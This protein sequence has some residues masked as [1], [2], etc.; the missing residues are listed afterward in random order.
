[1]QSEEVR[2]QLYPTSAV[3]QRSAYTFDPGCVGNVG[4]V[5]AFSEP[6]EAYS[7][8]DQQDR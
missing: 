6:L 4:G 8:H 2:S 3:T 7:R 5:L 1:L